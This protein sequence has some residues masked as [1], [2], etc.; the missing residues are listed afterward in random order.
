MIGRRG[1]EDE[2]TEIGEIREIRKRGESAGKSV[3]SP[4][5]LIFE[6][7]SKLYISNEIRRRF[8]GI[9]IVEFEESVLGFECQF[10][11]EPRP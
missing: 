5:L 1:R 6:R 11:D 10:C 3:V 9:A 7:D 8:G 4:K 2:S